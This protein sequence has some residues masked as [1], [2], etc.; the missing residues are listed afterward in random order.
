MNNPPIKNTV[1]GK[2][3]FI[4]KIGLGY[5]WAVLETV[6]RIWAKLGSVKAVLGKKRV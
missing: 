5:L 4:L 3:L 1:R 6:G 2:L